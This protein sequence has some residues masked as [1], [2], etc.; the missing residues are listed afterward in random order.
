ML[1]QMYWACADVLSVGAQLG[2]ARDLPSADV[3][4]RRIS[5]VLEQMA[6]RAR[7]AHI[8]EDD[9]AEARYALVAFLDEK[10]L[11]SE[12]PGKQAWQA[13][14]LQL[15]YFNENTAG[16]GFF[17][18]LQQLENTPRRAHV[19]EIYYLCMA[20]GFRGQYW[21]RGEQGLAAIMDGVG[22]KLNRLLPPT[23]VISPK[24]LPEGNVRS[25]VRREAPI[26]G[27][28]LGLLALSI[29]LFIVLRIVL[30]VSASNASTEMRAFTEQTQK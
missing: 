12:W 3:L 10:I 26:V 27:A 9:I 30:S 23:D 4:Q 2:H 14:P 5:S 25:I 7:A 6:D 28:S 16:E 24:G 17:L 8:P 19:L 15:I 22:R 13:R 20:L 11:S 18:H 21:V 1:E 29:V